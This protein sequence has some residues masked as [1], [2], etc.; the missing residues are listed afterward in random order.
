MLK[1]LSLRLYMLLISALCWVRSWA[2]PDD[3]DDFGVGGGRG[4]DSDDFGDMS[5]Y[6]DYQ[7]FH[8]GFDD[9]V[10]VVFLLIICYVFGKIWKGCTYLILILAALFYYMTRY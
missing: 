5:E 10:M 9:I 2:Q 3:D 8:I 6:M 1:Q 4:G 7:P